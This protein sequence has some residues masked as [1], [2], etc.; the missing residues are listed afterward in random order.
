MYCFAH[1]IIT[2]LVNREK[3]YH[4]DSQAQSSRVKNEQMH[5]IQ[6]QGYPEETLLDLK[7]YGPA[8]D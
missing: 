7:L 2:S 4:V 8:I 3:E 6:N 1:K 5:L